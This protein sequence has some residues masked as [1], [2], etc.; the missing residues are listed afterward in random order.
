MTAEDQSRRTP[1]FLQEEN[2]RLKRAVD[3]LQLLNQLAI[4]IGAALDPQQVLKKLVNGARRAVHA[5]Q[6]VIFLLGSEAGAQTII[7]VTSNPH[8][9]LKFRLQES[10]VGWMELHKE[11]LLV[12]DTRED[13][14]F[15]REAWDEKVRSLLSAPLMVKSKLIGVLTTFNKKEGQSF[16]ADDQRVLAIL[17]S[18]S[19]QIVERA[20]LYE[21][22]KELER[23]KEDMAVAWEIQQHLLPQAPP[24]VVG[25]DIA[26]KTVPARTVGGDFFDFIKVEP[27]RLAFCLGD[28]AG[29]GLP[30]ALLMAS[31]QATVR[32]QTL[33]QVTERECLER[34]NLLL[35]R[36]TSP[37]RFATLFYATLD[38]DKHVLRYSNA[39]HNYPFHLS[40]DGHSQ[41]LQTGGPLLGVFEEW[42]IELDEIPFRSGDLLV[43]FSD[44]ITDAMD[45]REEPF[46]DERLAAVIEENR[47][48]S[49][50]ELLSTIVDAVER[51]SRNMPQT[52][53][54]TLVVIKRNHG[55][56]QAKVT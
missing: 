30:A 54:I 32:G 46:G 7:R 11:P 42:S 52:D 38:T 34:S 2:Q 48:Q 22:E 15:Q 44:G 14:R 12:N 28:V 31:L 26:G 3:E 49:A 51:Y 23:L 16:T 40:Q 8:E 53:D 5:E 4:E 20:R 10:V 29:K 13:S 47:D 56:E 39:G 36:S 21:E 1:E 35:C 9:H 25:Y 41:R 6:G 43:V 50:H 33:I 55:T 24:V 17:A 27:H 19:A 18:Q 37:E 45:E